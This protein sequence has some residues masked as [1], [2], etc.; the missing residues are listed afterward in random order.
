MTTNQFV[1]DV[2]LDKK[3]WCFF[4]GEDGPRW[5]TREELFTH[6]ETIV[7]RDDKGGLIIP[8]GKINES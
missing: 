3:Y 6:M 1:K 2:I 8:R 7:H 4:C 5:N